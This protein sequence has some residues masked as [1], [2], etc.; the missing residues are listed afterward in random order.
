TNTTS[1]VSIVNNINVSSTTN[2][3]S[4]VSITDI[5]RR[6]NGVLSI[7]SFAN[8]TSNAFIPRDICFLSNFSFIRHITALDKKGNFIPQIYF[9]ITQGFVKIVVPLNTSALLFFTDDD[10]YIKKLRPDLKI[11]GKYRYVDE[12][13]HLATIILSR[14]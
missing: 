3:T 14:R 2:T 1:N 6:E 10:V 8:I 7:F 11:K 5:I 12:P 4:N 13:E 9:I